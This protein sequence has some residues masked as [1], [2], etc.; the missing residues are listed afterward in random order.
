MSGIDARASTASVRPKAEKRRLND[1]TAKEWV[2]ETVSVWV[3]KGLGKNHPHAK[4]ERQHPA[5]FSFQDVGRAIRLLTR[6]GDTVIDPFVGVGSTLKAAA[7]DGRNGIGI[8]LSSKYADLARERLLVEVP[9]KQLAKTTQEV[10]VGDARKVLPMLDGK[11]ASLVIT[12]PP[13]WNILHKVDHKARQERISQD[14]DHVYGGDVSDLGNINDYASFVTELGRIFNLCK[15]AM[16]V[17]GH[18]CAV[19]SDFR[20]KS[21]YYL[22]HADLAE[23]LESHGFVTKGLIVLWQSQKRIFPYGYPSAF[24]P[25][26]H[27][28]YLLIS[29]VGYGH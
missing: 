4:I 5:P 11:N 20:H 17:D 29:Q 7:L 27:H 24:V 16:T 19:V 9:E 8:E 2:R 22:F 13:Y 26:V 25:N 28:Q 12:S 15:G 6:E 10:I 3:Q 1:L 18:L 23:E 21:K 14:L